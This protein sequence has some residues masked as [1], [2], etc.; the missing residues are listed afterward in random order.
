MLVD[1]PLPGNQPTLVLPCTHCS[2]SS[3]TVHLETLTFL[4]AQMTGWSSTVHLWLPSKVLTERSMHSLKV[5]PMEVK[6]YGPLS[7]L[8]DR[9]L[10]NAQCRDTHQRL[11]M[12]SVGCTCRLLNTRCA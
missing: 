10:C 2:H 1:I 9:L 7:I 8:T 5:H 4:A 6:G 11:L 12:T 3:M